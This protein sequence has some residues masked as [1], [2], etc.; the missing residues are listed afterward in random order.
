MNGFAL[1]TG[2]S[3]GIGEAFARLLAADGVPLILVARSGDDLSRLKASLLADVAPGL[4]IVVIEADL[5][6]VSAAASLADAVE[7]RNLD[8]DLLINNAGV[9][10]YGPFLNHAEARL[11]AI[12]TLNMVAPTMLCRHFLP[13][14]VERG[15]GGVINVASTSAFQ[16]TPGMAAYGA[17]KSYLLSLTEALAI[18]LEGTGV[19]ATALCPG[20]TKTHFMAVA[21]MSPTLDDRFFESADAVAR[22]GLAAFR[23]G[24]TVQVSGAMNWVGAQGQRLLPRKTLAR[25]SGRILKRSLGG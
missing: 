3:R 13:K 7:S 1:V 5:A 11:L 12:Q 18:E 6:D 19:T 14:M 22:T 2:A 9:G 17:T 8:V 4:E 16:P 25:I 20:P 15:S 10:A 24:R 21:D 23:A